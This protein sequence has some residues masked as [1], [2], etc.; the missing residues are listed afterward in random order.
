MHKIHVVILCISTLEKAGNKNLESDY[1]QNRA[2][3][4]AGFSGK[5]GTGFF[6]DVKTGNANSKGDNCYYPRA[7]DRHGQIIIGN[8]K[9]YGKGVNR[10]GDTLYKKCG[11]TDAGLFFAGAAGMETFPK[12]F[13]ANKGQEYQGDPWNEVFK[14]FK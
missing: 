14:R 11:N 9:A 4:N 6:A 13:T 8:S 2:A 7:G 3:K 12:H 10:C 1:D 5:L